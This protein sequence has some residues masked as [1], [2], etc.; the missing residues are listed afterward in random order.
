M[1]LSRTP[2]RVSLPPPPPRDRPEPLS[3]QTPTE[4]HT[5]RSSRWTLKSDPEHAHCEEKFVHGPHDGRPL[6]I[7][8]HVA[9]RALGAALERAPAARPRQRVFPCFLQ[10]TVYGISATGSIRARLRF[11]ERFTRFFLGKI[12]T[13]TS[14]IEHIVRSEIFDSQ[15][16]NQDT[17]SENGKHTSRRWRARR[18]PCPVA[19]VVAD[20]P[21]PVPLSRVHSAALSLSLSL[22]LASATRGRVGTWDASLARPRRP[23]STHFFK[24]C[25]NHR[26]STRRACG[27]VARDDAARALTDFGE[28]HRQFG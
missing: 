24:K 6:H 13:R 3:H 5:S 9:A 26:F 14:S 7:L 27:L 15:L 21:G 20:P 12:W 28:G 17:E 23:L 2:Y 18:V 4:L 8:P 1:W 11:G 22:S 25:T 19:E 16:S 10:S